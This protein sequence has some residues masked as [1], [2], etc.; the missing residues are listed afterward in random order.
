MKKN[1]LFVMGAAA[2]LFMASCGSSKTAP[3]AKGM[4]DIETPCS[5]TE[6]KSTGDYLRAS[7]M[8]ISTNQSTAKKKAMQDARAALAQALET[9]VKAV[10]DAF[11]SSYENGLDEES[12][13][14]FMEM[15][16]SVTSQ[17][18]SG[19]LPIC[20]KMQQAPDGKYHSFVAVE[21]SGKSYLEKVAA[22]ITSDEKLRI[23]YEYEKF[24][25]VFE[26][27]MAD[28]ENN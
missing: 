6:Y 15:T 7:S 16:R 4:V 27:E 13:G 14:R 11:V 25:E 22:A 24:K 8:S 2:M 18:L 19:V 21:L 17:T 3:A 28:L 12:K 5:G 10:T 9:K 26:Q 1:F 20:E 23:D